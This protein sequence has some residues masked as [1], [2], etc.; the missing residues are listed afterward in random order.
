MRWVWLAVTIRY[1]IVLNHINIAI[2]PFKGFIS[3]RQ[4]LVLGLV[5]NLPLYNLLAEF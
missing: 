2:K 4:P 1:L 3:K 5:E